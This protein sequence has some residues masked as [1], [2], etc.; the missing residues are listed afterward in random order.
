MVDFDVNQIE[1]A[2]IWTVTDLIESGQLNEG[3]IKNFIEGNSQSLQNNPLFK[4]FHESLLSS[5][6]LKSDL[7]SFSPQILFAA[8][9]YVSAKAEK[10]SYRNALVKTLDESSVRYSYFAT[11]ACGLSPD[12][13]IIPVDVECP[14]P[15]VGPAKRADRKVFKERAATLNK[16]NVRLSDSFNYA[17]IQSALAAPINS[18]GLMEYLESTIRNLKSLPADSI[19]ADDIAIATKGLD[20]QLKALSRIELN[21]DFASCQWNSECRPDVVLR[22]LTQVESSVN[23]LERFL[24]RK[25][26]HIAENTTRGQACFQLENVND[27]ISRLPSKL[28]QV[29][30]NYQ[31]LSS[32]VSREEQG[33]EVERKKKASELESLKFASQ[34]RLTN[35]TSQIETYNAQ[36]KLAQNDFD[37]TVVSLNDSESGLTSSIS[38]TSESIKGLEKVLDLYNLKDA[39]S[40]SSKILSSMKSLEEEF[41]A[42]LRLTEKVTS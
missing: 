33:L 4:I 13:V 21:R 10:Q 12:E 32:N 20:N 40:S 14:N 42:S 27:Q 28:D 23:A 29:L 5:L 16:L 24:D 26:T 2:L 36:L 15:N 19:Y 3:T 11:Q 37:Q 6:K 38:Q 30:S 34:E 25:K 17:R 31:D 35:Y 39:Q 9:P 18:V 41:K 7:S 1:L 8:L 22:K